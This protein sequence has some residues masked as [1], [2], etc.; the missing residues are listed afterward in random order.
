[1]K[2][3]VCD[4]CIEDLTE[5]NKLLDLYRKKN[6]EVSFDV[7][8]FSDSAKLYRR[9]QTENLGDIYLLDLI[10]SNKTG[11]DIGSL[12]RRSG[13]HCVIIYITSSDE[14]ALDAYRL[15]AAR[16][17]LKPIQADLF[18]EA[19]DYAASDLL[20]I[21]RE[22]DFLVKTK[23]GL[24][25]APYSQIEYIENCSRT[26]HVRLSSGESISSIFIRGSFE[27]EIR[28]LLQ[29]G[30]FLHV[31]KS[32]LVNMNNI[33]SLAQSLIIMD[34]GKQIPISKNRA[35]EVKKTYLM[36]VSSEYR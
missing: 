21:S 8:Y 27:E 15:R 29:D 1:M 5:I 3:V 19:L 14:Y 36:F 23:E 6:A 34:S 11:I 35:A 16:Y 25:S 28:P 30:R 9:I 20:R 26:L 24:I 32:F 22:A 7:L 4:D 13:R 12:I 33:H 2:I 10:M 17:L 31:H 18:F